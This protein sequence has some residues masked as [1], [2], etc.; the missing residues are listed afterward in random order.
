MSALWCFDCIMLWVV[1]VCW[2]ECL[3]LLA[4]WFAVIV[5]WYYLGLC[6]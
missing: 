5:W 3:A 1:V 2:G 4:L 6:A